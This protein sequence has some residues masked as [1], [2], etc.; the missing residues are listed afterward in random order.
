VKIPGRVVLAMDGEWFIFSIKISLKV[1][2]FFIYQTVE[3]WQKF[4]KVIF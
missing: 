1:I 2:Q 4:E 3:S